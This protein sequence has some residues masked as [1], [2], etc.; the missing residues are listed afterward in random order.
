MDIVIRGK[1]E[2]L[3]MDMSQYHGLPPH[4]DWS[5]LLEEQQ[6]PMDDANDGE[7]GD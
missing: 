7:E 6:E 5:C 3:E 4:L 1:V 2:T